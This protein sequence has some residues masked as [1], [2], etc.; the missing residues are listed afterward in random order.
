MP[1]LCEVGLWRNKHLHCH[2]WQ[3]IIA[4]RQAANESL[5]KQSREIKCPWVITA[6]LFW[7]Q[8][9]EAKQLA[10]S[11]AHTRRTTISEVVSCQTGKPPMQ[12]QK[13]FASRLSMSWAGTY[14]QEMFCVLTS[15]MK[16]WHSRAP[17]N[18]HISSE[19]SRQIFWKQ[20]PVACNLASCELKH[21]QSCPYCS[22]NLWNYQQ[23]YPIFI[24][25][26]FSAGGTKLIR[27]WNQ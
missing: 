26:T 22:I 11:S 13:R 15:N 5:E 3:K 19:G 18:K 2:F 14:G 7:V 25:F 10:P 27:Q 4:P 16:M 23:Q 20:P 17:K 9:F 21:T 1:N 8:A 24:V 6:L 12:I